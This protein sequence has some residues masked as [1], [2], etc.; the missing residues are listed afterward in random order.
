MSQCIINS[1][2]SIKSSEVIKQAKCIKQVLSNVASGELANITEKRSKGEI[3]VGA[4]QCSSS[5]FVPSSTVV[6][7]IKG[8]GKNKEI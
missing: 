8:S 5:L 7:W 1:S 6:L 2:R 4:R 3:R